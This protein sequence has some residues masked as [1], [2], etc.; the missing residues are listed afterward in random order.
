VALKVEMGSGMVSGESSVGAVVFVVLV[1]V[2][3]YFCCC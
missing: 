3:V 2:C 1:C